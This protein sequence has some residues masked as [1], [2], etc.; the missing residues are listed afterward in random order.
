[1]ASLSGYS[2][3]V[4][5]PAVLAADSAS[6]R[7]EVTIDPAEPVLEGHYPGFPV[8]PGVCLVEHVRLAA[9]AVLPEADG[10]RL[11]AVESCQF[12]RPALPGDT[13]LIEAVWRTADEGRSCS[14]TLT[15]ER[16]IIARLRLRLERAGANLAD[17][18]HP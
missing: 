17:V 11:A 1:M 5:R 10:W 4:A 13:L 2:P 14:A 8:F 16:G 3:L 15:S 18:G 7:A 9:L 12:L 6:F